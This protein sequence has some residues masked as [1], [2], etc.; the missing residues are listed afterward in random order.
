M[1]FLLTSE[2]TEE[3]FKTACG[4]GVTYNQEEMR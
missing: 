3:A 2:F 1:I 4:V